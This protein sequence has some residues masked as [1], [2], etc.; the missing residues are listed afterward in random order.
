[1]CFQMILT[2][3]T[4]LILLFKHL[5]KFVTYLVSTHVINPTEKVTNI[6]QMCSGIEIN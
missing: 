2:A 4:R 1:M 5:A 3:G 6:H